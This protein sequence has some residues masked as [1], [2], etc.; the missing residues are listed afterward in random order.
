MP[1]VSLASWSRQRDVPYGPYGNGEA[2][3]VRCR[4]SGAAP[5]AD[6]ARA[7]QQATGV[8]GHPAS[9][10]CTF[11]A[12]QN[13]G[14]RVVYFLLP[15]PP[16]AARPAVRHGWTGAS[17]CGCRCPRR[18]PHAPPPPRTPGVGP[19]AIRMCGNRSGPPTPSMV[20]VAGAGEPHL[21]LYFLLPR[22]NLVGFLVSKHPP[23]PP[24][25]IQLLN[26]FQIG[27]FFYVCNLVRMRFDCQCGPEE[28][29]RIT[30][31]HAIKAL[32][33]KKQPHVSSTM[34]RSILNQVHF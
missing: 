11:R 7:V 32:H 8:R 9:W 27:R 26:F 25:C 24:F 3:G 20:P 6:L 1:R 15:H 16:V 33:G 19:V 29:V 17:R 31:S 12:S 23:K 14:P 5:L 10:R 28:F 13:T 30:E 34:G 4:G 22:N 18:R 21:L 2:V